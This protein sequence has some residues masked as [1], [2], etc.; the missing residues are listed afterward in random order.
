MLPAQV[1]RAYA[2][3]HQQQ[4]DTLLAERDRRTGRGQRHP[5]VDFLF[6]YYAIRPKQLRTWHPG[7]GVVLKE[8]AE[9]SDRR[10]YIAV[11]SHGV[12][13]RKADPAGFTQGDFAHR[14]DH[15]RSVLARLQAIDARSARLNCFGLH[16]WAMVHGL[17]QAEVR[18]SSQPLRVDPA[19]VSAT[20]ADLGL[21]CSHFDAFRFFTESAIPLNP[22]H[23][24]SSNRND[25]EQPGCLHNAMDLYRWAA[26]ALPMSSSDLVVRCFELATDARAVDMRASPYDLTNLGYSAIRIETV[27]GRREYVAEQRRIAARADVLRGELLVVLETA[28][29]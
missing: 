20:V 23:L 4:I 16:E 14:G 3:A 22:I 9:F 1:W 28:V 5:V 25:H 2:D 21:A 18:H 7:T 24:T 12:D 6:R 8:A 13:A 29:A 17:T 26:E 10:G 19:T 27:E 15:L 11:P